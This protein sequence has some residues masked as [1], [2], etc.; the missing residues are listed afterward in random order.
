ML[1]ESFQIAEYPSEFFPR[2]AEFFRI[3]DSLPLFPWVEQLGAAGEM[4]RIPAYR[5]HLSIEPCRWKKVG[6]GKAEGWRI[7]SLCLT[8]FGYG[9]GRVRHPQGKLFSSHASRSILRVVRLAGEPHSHPGPAD[10][11][12]P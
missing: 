2:D 6:A 1:V 8:A 5:D 4:F 10:S 11:A 9:A 3:H 7:V 12:S